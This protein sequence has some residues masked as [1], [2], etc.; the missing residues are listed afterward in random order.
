MLIKRVLNFV[1]Y[2]LFNQTVTLTTYCMD[3]EI[4]M[5]ERDK[6]FTE[7][8]IKSRHLQKILED[9]LII[10]FLKEYICDNSSNVYG[11]AVLR[12]WIISEMRVNN[13]FK[14]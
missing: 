1:M 3:E 9:E 5:Y 10:D 12:G 14:I 7:F 8:R 2:R 4:E 13:L 6:Y 11:E